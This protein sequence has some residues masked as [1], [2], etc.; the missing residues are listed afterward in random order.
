MKEKSW[1]TKADWTLNWISRTIQSQCQ[2]YFFYHGA[3]AQCARAPHYRGFMMKFR[4]ATLGRT[5]LDEWSAR[6]R[7]LYLTTHNT[8]KRQIFM[9]P[10]G[11]KTTM[12]AAERPQTHALDRAANG[13]GSA[14][15]CR[16][17]ILI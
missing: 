10:T 7:D 14:N 12:S 16:R 11:F 8:H 17:R 13:T 1:K 2:C 3:L 4:H 9:P 6:R 15:A 5:P